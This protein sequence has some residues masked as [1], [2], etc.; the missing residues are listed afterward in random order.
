MAIAI[1]AALVV[2][3]LREQ[4]RQVAR[5]QLENH[6]RPWFQDEGYASF[7]SEEGKPD[8]EPVQPLAA[9]V[10][11]IAVR[12]EDRFVYFG[13]DF[14]KRTK[15]PIADSLANV[16]TV[17]I[18]L[19]TIVLYSM[20]ALAYKTTIV[21]VDARTRTVVARKSF[22]TERPPSHVTLDYMTRWDDRFWEP[23]A[24]WIDRL[25]LRD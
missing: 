9:P 21:L 25:P 19:E 18:S 10:V 22:S 11:P 12:G 5:A 1:V 2:W 3:K 8:L 13:L 7:Y 16:G 4:A 6:V 20:G 23:I 15:L 14:A 24:A 17:A